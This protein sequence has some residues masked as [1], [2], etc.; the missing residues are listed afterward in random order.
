MLLGYYSDT[1]RQTRLDSP[2]TYG[3]WKYDSWLRLDYKTFFAVLIESRHLHAA[4]SHPAWAL[5]RSET[6]LMSTRST[7][8]NLLSDGQCE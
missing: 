4:N 6:K 5:E 7:A 3:N 2:C 1:A 8:I